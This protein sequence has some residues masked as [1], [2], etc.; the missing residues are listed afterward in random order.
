MSPSDR[1][2]RIVMVCTGNICRSPMAE[3]LL[4]HLLPASLESC[5]SVSSAGTSALHGHQAA[6]HAV[7]AMAQLGIDIR[8]HRARQLNSNTVQRADLILAMENSHL[9]IIARASTWSKTQ[10]RLL[11]EFGPPNRTPD[12][13]DPYGKSLKAYQA[14]LATLRPCIEGLIAW[15]TEHPLS[16]RQKESHNKKLT[17]WHPPK[18][19]KS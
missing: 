10:A 17:L 14:C 3:W 2:Y 12:I 9:Q 5:V 11:T 19:T 18:P 1:E 15:L 6:D 16:Q 7:T 8:N 13:E 4:K